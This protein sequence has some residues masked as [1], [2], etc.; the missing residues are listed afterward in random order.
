MF[1]RLGFLI[2]KRVEVFQE[3]EMRLSD[4]EK[5]SELWEA[6][7]IQDYKVG[8]CNYMALYL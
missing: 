3:V 6:A 5:S 7:Q 4:A 1:E 2:T 8:W